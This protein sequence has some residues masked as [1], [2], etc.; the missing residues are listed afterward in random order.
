LEQ[1]DTAGLQQCL[2]QVLHQR[3]RG[4]WARKVSCRNEADLLRQHP[5]GVGLRAFVMALAEMAVLRP[6]PPGGVAEANPEF[7]PRVSFGLPQP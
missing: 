7:T 3:L 2:R 5:L 1:G 4:P 6:H